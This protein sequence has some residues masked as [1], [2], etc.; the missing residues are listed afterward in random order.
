MILMQLFSPLKQ[1]TLREYIC[2][3]D[4]FLRDFGKEEV[5]RLTLSNYLSKCFSKALSSGESDSHAVKLV[6]LLDRIL[7][8]LG[9]SWR[10][11]KDQCVHDLIASWGK[12]HHR[13]IKVARSGLSWVEVELL[14]KNPPPKCSAWT[15]KTYILVSWAFLLRHQEADKLK[16]SD[17]SSTW[18]GTRRVW[19][20]RVL[21]AKTAR[22]LGEVQTVKFFDDQLPKPIIPLLEDYQKLPQ[23]FQWKVPQG[24]LIAHIRST[25]GISE[26]EKS[27]VFH[28]LRHGRATFCR[29]VLGFDLQQLMAVGRWKSAEAVQ[30]YMHM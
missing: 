26:N 1:A 5:N 19:E 11:S 20:V 6:A 30:V 10:P 16:P 23:N 9:R 3:G 14:A 18:V 15:C 8:S 27:V 2:Q 13:Y 24:G 22:N 12:Y 17:L 7:S 25:L 28:S 29:K 4:R 21:N